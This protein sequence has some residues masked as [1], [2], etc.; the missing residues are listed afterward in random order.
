MGHAFGQG[1]VFLPEK[2]VR[3][4]QRASEIVRPVLLTELRQLARVQILRDQH[5]VLV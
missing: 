1:I 4:R 5:Q 3:N 2:H